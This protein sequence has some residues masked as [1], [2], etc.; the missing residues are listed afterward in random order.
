[1][2]KKVCHVTS[3]HRPTD[4]RIFERECTSLTKFYDVTLIAPNVE[5]YE[6]NGVHVKG[7]SLPKSRIKRMIGLDVVMKKMVE[8]DADLYHLH[9]PE[10]IPIGLKIKKMGKKIIFDSHENVPVQILSKPYLPC[11]KLIS[12]IYSFYE[13]KSFRKYDALVSVT[14]EI[15]D[16][17]KKI[18]SQTYMLTNY[19]V[20]EEFIPDRRWYRKLVFAGAVSSNWGIHIIIDV[21]K[22]LDLS[23]EIAGPTSEDYLNQ[24]K[25]IPGWNKVNYHGRLNPSE[26]PDLLSQC[27]IGMALESYDNPNAGYRKGSIGVTKIYEYMM[28]GIPVIATDLDNWIPIVEGNE[29]GFCIN[30]DDKDVIVEKIKY[31]LLHT[32]EAK[33]LGDNG[34][35]AVKEKYCWQKQEEVLFK[36]YSQLLD[37]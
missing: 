18:N 25:V 27:S 32:D 3:V 35:K 23:F 9:D 37:Q 26:V 1:M 7:V 31:L 30:R 34:R 2:L 8:V 22:N 33:R 28:A 4:K 19:P 29:C 17:L 20:Y 12:C 14:P 24:L 16:R 6:E 21:I 15:V 10:L 5:D 36:M 13:K 11:R